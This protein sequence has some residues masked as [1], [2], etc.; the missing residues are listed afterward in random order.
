MNIPENFKLVKTNFGAFA[1]SF[2]KKTVLF[3]SRSIET[4]EFYWMVNNG[5][6][7]K[8]MNKRIAELS[9]L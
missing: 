7:S 5:W 4:G 1:I 2:D 8:S 9:G 3:Y 6:K